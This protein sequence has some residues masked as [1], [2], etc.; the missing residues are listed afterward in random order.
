MI[1]LVVVCEGQTEQTFVK[2]C[3][4]PELAQRQ[5]YVNP[6]L[7]STGRDAKGGALTKD[8]VLHRLP[9]IVKQRG[10]VYVS[11][12]FDLY[13][14]ASNFP[15]NNKANAG[16]DPIQR[17]QVIEASLSKA[18]VEAAQ[19]RPERFLP[20]IQP[21]E[22]ESLLFSDVSLFGTARPEWAASVSRL[23]A[24]R[25]SAASPEHINDGAETHPSARLRHNLTPRYK[26]P[27]DG[28]TIA[29]RI[30]LPRIR[31]ECRH[32]GSWL[33]RIENLPPLRPSA[34]SP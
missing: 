28:S 6:Q 10:D 16:V 1:E 22:F 29:A 27:L 7:I 3:L 30:G 20:H 24:A 17:A 19:C 21:Y 25:A 32:F 26:K 4:A 5:I 8:R 31:A 12:F 14:L 33:D 18:V 11:T 9:R 13:G 34:A 23:E 2:E 15:G